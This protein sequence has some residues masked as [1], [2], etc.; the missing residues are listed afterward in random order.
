M[1][2]REVTSPVALSVSFITEANGTI[3][4]AKRPAA[5]AAAWRCCDWSE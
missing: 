2:A 5:W 4:S 1:I 3:S